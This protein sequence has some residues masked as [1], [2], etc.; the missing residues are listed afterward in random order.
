MEK[1]EG[2]VFFG[3]CCCINAF[4][5]RVEGA[6]ASCKQLSHKCALQMKMAKFVILCLIAKHCYFCSNSWRCQKNADM[7]LTLFSGFMKPIPARPSHRHPDPVQSVRVR[8]SV[9]SWPSRNST[10]PKNFSSSLLKAGLGSSGGRETDGEYIQSNWFILLF[11]LSVG[12]AI[13]KPHL[14]AV[15]AGGSAQRG[16]FFLYYGRG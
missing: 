12:F 1:G 5:I 6:K 13:K 9:I 14:L 2:S 10:S 11:S 15:S 16:I 8:S 4:S 3:P 7:F